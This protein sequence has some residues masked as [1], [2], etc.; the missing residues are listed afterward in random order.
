MRAVL[1]FKQKLLVVLHAVFAAVVW[2][3]CSSFAVD[4][5][6]EGAVYEPIEE[7]V[8][9]T[10]LRL[11]AR[12][13]IKGMQDDLRHSAEN[14]T[15]ELPSYYLP[16]A[17]KTN[18]RWKDAGGLVEEDIYMP[19]IPDWETG[20][21]TE[22]QPMLLAKKGTY[23]NMLTELPVEAIPRIFLFDG[24]DPDQL[25]LAKELAQAKLENLALIAIAGDVKDLSELL[26]GPVYHPGN[27]LLTQMN[28]K[29]VP[30][31]L[32]FGKGWHQGHIAITEFAT[33]S[34]VDQVKAAW[35]GLVAPQSPEAFGKKD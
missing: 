29:A 35:F 24:T 10:F 32:G 26:D 9:I 21:V 13:D 16:R 3:P 31:L 34:S 7:D 18:T 2:L 30:T 12:A 14:F 15:K 8:R 5:G 33:P 25:G 20:S 27:Q 19:G 17:D 28:V 4:L 22:M 11:I 6:I 23:V 1:P